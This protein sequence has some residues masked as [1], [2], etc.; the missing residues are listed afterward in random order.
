MN[1]ES[2]VLVVFAGQ[3]FFLPVYP[4]VSIHYVVFQHKPLKEKEDSFLRSFESGEMIG[5]LGILGIPGILGIL[6]ISWILGISFHVMVGNCSLLMRS[7][8]IP[9]SL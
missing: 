9:G 6:G 4:E 8:V 5:S 7:L 1:H 3:R 2:V